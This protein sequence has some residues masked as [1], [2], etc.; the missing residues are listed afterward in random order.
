MCHADEEMNRS[1]RGPQYPPEGPNIDEYDNPSDLGFWRV[2]IEDQAAF[3]CN[4]LDLTDE[5]AL[6]L[7]HALGLIPEGAPLPDFGQR[8][9]Q[10]REWEDRERKEAAEGEA[11]RLCCGHLK[12]ALCSDSLRLPRS[13]LFLTAD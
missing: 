3:I 8:E 11:Q 9:R 10:R 1:S 7:L 4:E 12:R 2:D 5:Q 6:Y 13:E